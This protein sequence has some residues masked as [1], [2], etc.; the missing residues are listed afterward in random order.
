M[1]LT[2]AN[3]RF[4]PKEAPKKPRAITYI[5]GF[6]LY[7]GLKS[8]GFS[9]YYWLDL[10]AISEK[11]VKGDAELIGV[12]YFT[13]RISSP[14]GKR[15][16]QNAFI[17]A[18]QVGGGVELFFGKFASQ[19][20]TCP[21]CG[22]ITNV[23]SEKM[24]D[25]NIATQMLRD[26]FEDS[27]DTAILVSADSDLSAPVRTVREMFPHKRVEI[28]FPPNRHSKELMLLANAHDRITEEWLKAC[29]FPEQISKP[30]GFIIRRPTNWR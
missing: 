19:P 2:S 12:K 16:R 11:F 21:L 9:R 8:S 4:A 30:N 18:I 5:D 24:T 27:Y 14:E 13:S 15:R 28:I 29:Q 20:Y 23:P 1:S 6:N 10:R 22:G 25:V 3:L 7:F 17:D 26:A